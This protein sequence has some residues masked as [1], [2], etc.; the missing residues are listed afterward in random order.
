MVETLLIALLVL[1]TGTLIV[2]IILLTRNSLSDFDKQQERMERSLKEEMTQNRGEASLNAK[3]L[4]EEIVNSMTKISNLQKDQ[5]DIFS[6]QLTTLTRTNEQ[7]LD[8]MRET[9][10][11]RLKILQEDNPVD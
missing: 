11:E 1:V 8:K 3:Q 10:E 2:S 5:L 9:V 7:K 4:R 6:T